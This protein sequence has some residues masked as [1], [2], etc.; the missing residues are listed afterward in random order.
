[1]GM[2]GE[3]DSQLRGYSVG[4]LKAAERPY[5]HQWWTA[6]ARER[7][8]LDDISQHAAASFNHRSLRSCDGTRPVPQR[9]AANRKL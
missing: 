3:R 9:L 7:V 6:R 4:V 2:E 8:L 5:T 1:M